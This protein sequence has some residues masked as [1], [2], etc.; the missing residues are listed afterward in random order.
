[1]MIT[2]Q[3][4]CPLQLPCDKPESSFLLSLHIISANVFDS[5]N[6]VMGDIKRYQTIND[7][8][9]FVNCISICDKLPCDQSGVYFNVETKEGKQ[10]TVELSTAGCSIWDEAFDHR[11]SQS[12]ERS[13]QYFGT[14]YAL[15]DCVSSGYR[16]SF[17]SFLA[18]KSIW[19]HWW[20]IQHI[21]GKLNSLEF[22][23]NLDREMIFLCTH[24]AHSFRKSKKHLA[25]IASWFQYSSPNDIFTV[26]FRSLPSKQV[27]SFS[28]TRHSLMLSCMMR[29]SVSCFINFPV[30]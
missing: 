29:C 4:R 14:I 7:I 27:A 10:L 5:Q 6:L 16:E 13:T 22:F 28:L 25:Q 11:T 17:S 30:L 8:K 12:N 21:T 15:L 3:P 26:R 24:V 2:C 23:V 20:C 1:M 18:K 9:C 19:K